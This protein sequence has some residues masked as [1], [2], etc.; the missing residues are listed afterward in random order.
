[1]DGSRTITERLTHQHMASHLACSRE[2]VSRLLRDL[3]AGGVCGDA[4]AAFGFI[5]G[6]AAAVVIFDLAVQRIVTQRHSS[7]LSARC[8]ASTFLRMAQGMIWRCRGI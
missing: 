5:E 4:R 2:M 7:Q 1:L 8:T 6:F 3:Q